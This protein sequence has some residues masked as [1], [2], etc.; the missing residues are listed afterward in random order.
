[1]QTVFLLQYY[2]KCKVCRVHTWCIYIRCPPTNVS[3]SASRAIFISFIL[4]WK[5]VHSHR[6]IT[7]SC[8][9]QSLL[10]VR[11]K[12]HS[13]PAEKNLA[14]FICNISKKNFLLL[15]TN[16]CVTVWRAE[17]KWSLK[18]NTEFKT[19]FRSLERLSTDIILFILCCIM[20]ARKFYHRRCFNF[21]CAYLTVTLTR[22]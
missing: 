19:V 9:I 3:S 17:K 13:N 16:S 7:F 6:R 11:E 21:I 2:I 15:Q 20:K 1:M 4:Y 5:N 18:H 14:I 10:I 22:F 8:L 12:N